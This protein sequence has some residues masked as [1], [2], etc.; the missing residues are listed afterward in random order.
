MKGSDN[1]RSRSSLLA[2]REGFTV[3]EI[4]IVLVIIG[5]ILGAVIKGQD[6]ILGARTKKFIN[7]VNAWDIA[8]NAYLDRKGRYPGDTD[9]DGKIGDGNFKTDLIGAAFLSPPYEGDTGSEANT[10]TT[11]G[12]KFYVSF[13]TDGGADA[14]KNVVII[15]TASAT[16]PV[17]TSDELAFAESLDTS[18]DGSADG[19]AGQVIGAIAAAVITFTAAEWEATFAAAPTPTAWGATTT[20]IVWYFDKRR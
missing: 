8:A 6:L 12:Y 4:A 16:A 13:G 5:I 11:G 20:A 2:R 1:G 14:G 19:A 9:K 15:T 17:F 3:I 7:K 10:I 18:I